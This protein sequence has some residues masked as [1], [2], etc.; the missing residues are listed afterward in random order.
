[1]NYLKKRH[2]GQRFARRADI[3]P[4]DFYEGELPD[5]KHGNDELAWACCPFH[6]DHNP[7]FCVNLETGWFRCF[8][9][10]CG[11]TGANIVSFVSALYGMN[12]FEASRYL[13]VHHG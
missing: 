2:S 6:D 5:L 11:E 8:S 9:S 10:N 1:M 12:Y 3:D 13:E 7:S 4:A